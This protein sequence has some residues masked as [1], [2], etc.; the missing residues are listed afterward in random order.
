M[1]CNGCGSDRAAVLHGWWNNEKNTISYCCDICSKISTQ[2][3]PDVWYGYGSGTHT[4]ENIADPTTGKPIPFSSKREKMEA[5]KKAGVRE[6]GDK[7]HG[8][9]NESHLNRKTYFT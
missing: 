9:R 4:E 8:T 6:V 5:M 3:T 2:A 7:V 1:T